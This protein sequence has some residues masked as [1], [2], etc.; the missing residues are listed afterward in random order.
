MSILL[1]L[2]YPSALRGIIP[3]VPVL[4]EEMVQEIPAP[5]FWIFIACFLTG[6]TSTIWL[7]SRPP[8]E[9]MMKLGTRVIASQ[10]ENLWGRRSLWS[11]CLS[12]KY[13]QVLLLDPPYGCVTHVSQLSHLYGAR[14]SCSLMFLFSSPPSNTS[15][16]WLS[17]TELPGALIVLECLHFYNLILLFRRKFDSTPPKQKE[18]K[19]GEKSR[20]STSK[21]ARYKKTR[22]FS[23]NY[24]W[25][26]SAFHFTVCTGLCSHHLIE[27]YL[28][29][30]L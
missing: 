29:C 9:G 13:P 1:L 22:L 5:P 21:R 10:A 16:L 19:R 27:H 7:Q 2:I 17:V 20:S 3:C 18:N 4:A 11:C 25:L 14:I 23:F 26:W 30:I 28:Y 12:K 6:V 8:Q 15:C 24:S